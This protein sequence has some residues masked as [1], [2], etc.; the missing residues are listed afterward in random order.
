MAIDGIFLS[1]LAREIEPLCGNA[2]VDRVFQPARETLILALRAK[3]GN[4]K[5][6]MSASSQT[7]RIQLTAGSYE[8]P[9]A[10]PM[11]CMLLRK[12]LSGA[13]LCAVSQVS[14]DRILMLH[15]ENRN[16]LGDLVTLR[17][18]VE[19]MGRHSNIILLGEDG[20]IIDAIKRV[21]LQ[22][23]SV[24]PVLPGLPYQLPPG[25]DKLSLL[26]SEPEQVLERIC[27][28]PE[29]PL[30]KAVMNA[31]L[32]ISPVVAGEIAGYALRGGE[33]IVSSLDAEQLSRLR[34][35]LQEMKER[36]AAGGT[37][38]MLLTK[39]GKPKDL[40]F[41]EITQYSGLMLTKHYESY[42]ELLDA[43]FRERDLS[44]R[45]HQRSGD[46]FRFLANTS[47]RI[48]R[49][50]QHQREELLQSRD[51]DKLRVQ[52]DLINSNL[53]RLQKGETVARLENFYEPDSPLIDIPLDAR[54]TP[55]QN[56]QRY[57]AEYRKADTA[58][59]MLKTLIEK[60]EAEYA[61]IDTVLDELLRA[62]CEAELD[63]I[64]EELI[65]TGY[66]RRRGTGR[67]KRPQKLGPV[68]YRSSDGFQI[69]Q[70]RGNVQNDQLT[71]KD[72]QKGDIWFH[73]QNIPGSHVVIRTDGKPVPE[74]TLEEAA[75]IAAYNSKAKQSSLVPVDYTEIRNVRKPAGARPGFVLYVNYQTA[76]VTPDEELCE[77]LK[78]E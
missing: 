54:L 58:E 44:E 36:I 75:K 18:A 38:T 66:M 9:A 43:F 25:Q 28:Y 26:E 57:Y 19:I 30:H 62:T 53:Y 4:Q 55:A 29:L 74:R 6:L 35:F 40:C 45:M 42:S 23:S 51:R 17:L 5:L 31:I 8:N 7:P 20:K 32:G 70:G 2:R 52:A 59:R 12:H 56:A 15:F 41:L 16:E 48:E 77:R 14:L 68:R 65:A 76:V 34:F 39:E 78:E 46:L 13:K 27:S 21:D 61:Y 64:R 33:G 37:P 50:L 1:L 67:E 22:T 3:G 72:S 47:E 24:R 11:F 73:T 49:K 60:G 69:L 71:M 10:P 63:A